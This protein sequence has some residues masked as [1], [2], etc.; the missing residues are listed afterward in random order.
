MVNKGFRRWVRIVAVIGVFGLIAAACGD[1]D[2]GGGGGFE[3]LTRAELVEKAEAEGELLWYTESNEN[4]ATLLQDAFMAKYPNITASFI[5][6]SPPDLISRFLAEDA[7]DATVADMIQGTS[8]N[9]QIDGIDQGY[10]TAQDED[11]IPSL[12]ENYPERF[13]RPESGN[14]VNSLIPWGI[15]YNSDLVSGADVPTSFA[16][17]ADPKFKGQIMIADP[18]VADVYI[19]HWDAMISEVGEDVIAGIG[20]NVGRVFPNGVVA[21]QAVAAGEGMIELVCVSQ[22][23]LLVADEGAPVVYFTPSLTTGFEMRPSLVSKAPHPYAARLFIDFAMTPEGINAWSLTDLDPYKT[24]EIPADLL[25]PALDFL[26]RKDNV[27]SVLDL[28]SG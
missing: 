25:F 5:R 7:A 19:G 17:L 3:S 10:F 24:D 28:P 27:L 9:F 1:D 14:A 13:L 2:E 12:G 18:T 23:A 16:D 11:L 4:K 22:L 21:V 20:A 6:L 15:C 8:V 26:D